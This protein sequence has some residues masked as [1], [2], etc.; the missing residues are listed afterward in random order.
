MIPPVPKNGTLG[1]CSPILN[2]NPPSPPSPP[3]KNSFRFYPALGAATFPPRESTRSRPFGFPADMS[4][5]KE[6]GW[7]GEGRGGEKKITPK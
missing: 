1:R 6:E 7:R 4:S 2:S 5:L 3:K